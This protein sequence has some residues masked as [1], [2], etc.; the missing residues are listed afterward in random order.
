MGA[1]RV[2]TTAYSGTA[3]PEP[4]GPTQLSS[5]SEGGPPPGTA[6]PAPG[7]PGP[8]GPGPG[9]PP[10]PPL[11]PPEAVLDAW[12]TAFG[13]PRQQLRNILERQPA[14]V[15]ANPQLLS[16]RIAVYTRA[17]TISA[18]QLLYM[19]ARRPAVLSIAPSGV[20]ERLDDLGQ[21][22]GL[23]AEET[24]KLALSQP[25]F[26]E[27][28]ADTLR[29]LSS[30]VSAELKVRPAAAL[31]ILAGLPP[32][33]LPALMG[34]SPIVTGGAGPAGAGAAAAGGGSGAAAGPGVAGPA[35]V[36]GPLAERFDA[37]RRLLR[38]N[39][40]SRRATRPATLLLVSRCPALLALPTKAVAA[41]LAAL[42]T[43][44]PTKAA[45]GPSPSSASASPSASSPCTSPSSSASSS[46]SAP[47]S[48]GRQLL[49]VILSCPR[50]LTLPPEALRGRFV[51][52]AAAARI[53]LPA[54]VAMLLLQPRLLLVEPARLR[55]RLEGLIFQLMIP[56]RAAL[57]LVV[58]QPQLL[59]Y[60]TETL[61]ENWGA[62][63]GLLGI[64]FEAAL[65]MITRHPNLLC[66]SPATLSSK[67]AALEATFS[68]P[69]ARAVLLAVA[70]P[71]LLTFSERRFKRVHRVLCSV[72]PPMPGAALG[73]LVVREPALLLEDCTRLA[74][75]VS[76]AA[77][78]LALTEPEVGDM[79]S[80]S[81]HFITRDFRHW[82]TNLDTVVSRLGLALEGARAL[83]R[84]YPGLLGLDAAE[85]YRNAGTL[86]AYVRTSPAWAAQLDRAAP[87]LLHRLL[88]EHT[89]QTLEHLAFLVDSRLQSRQSHLAPIV[90][91]RAAFVQRYPGFEA[92]Q[93][94]QAAAARAPNGLPL[95]TGP[96]LPRQRQQRQGQ[97]SQAQQQERAGR[98]AAEEEVEAAGARG[99]EERGPARDVR[100]AAPE[101]SRVA[102]SA[103]ADRGTGSAPGLAEAAEEAGAESGGGGSGNGSGKGPS[104]NLIERP[105]RLGAPNYDSDGG[106]AVRKTA[107]RRL[108]VVRLPT[109]SSID[110]PPRQ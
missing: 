29:A 106:G 63:Q 56:R 13:L 103:A 46:A 31:R 28:Q 10:T 2:Q 67:L 83:V 37:L 64:T 81:P 35:V 88:R 54:V 70:R 32:E 53:D 30:R 105:R 19:I 98:G 49:D 33:S 8:A 5:A 90:W 97:K 12:V 73:R 50:I 85:L 44:P 6:A 4:S 18:Y 104:G 25:A 9:G 26:L 68:L 45:S 75:K 101:P 11:P 43:I 93:A 62:L 108:Q 80:R 69:H 89:P 59:L 86:M 1:D 16:E 65:S 55:A 82:Q 17:T 99:S 60:D 109:L 78:L 36:R 77:S 110:D 27:L 107:T 7:G 34:R 74:S 102:A 96:R 51:T 48:R 47:A 72:L 52:L 58:R 76:D 87:E 66:Y 38:E 20:A 100:P 14:L 79:L 22:L 15:R 23:S 84:R 41:T 42:M 40:G 24:V 3:D 94:Q 57:D 91:D 71:A 39:F 21:A 61:A 92:W 95:R